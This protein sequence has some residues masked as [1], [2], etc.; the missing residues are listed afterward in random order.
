MMAEHTLMSCLKAT[1]SE[2]IATLE[3]FADMKGEMWW[4][5]K[6]QKDHGVTLV[7]HIDTV[8]DSS[9]KK[10]EF[11]QVTHTSREVTVN[12]IR[13]RIYFDKKEGVIW[14][15]DGLGAD[16]RAGVFALFYIWERLPEELRPNLLFTDLEEKGGQGA[17]AVCKENMNELQKATAFVQF[18]RKNHQDAVFYNDEPK[19]FREYVC[20]FGFKEANGSFSDV[21]VIGKETQTCAVNLSCGYYDQHTKGEHLYIS[22]LFGSLKNALVMIQ[23][24]QADDRKWVNEAK[25]KDNWYRGPVHS[26]SCVCADC[27]RY[28]RLYDGL[29][30]NAECSPDWGH[31]SYDKSLSEEVSEA[32]R[33]LFQQQLGQK[34]VE[35]YN[36]IKREQGKK[37]KKGRG[38]AHHPQCRCVVCV[39]R[40]FRLL[41]GQKHHAWCGCEHCNPTHGD[42]ITRIVGPNGEL[43]VIT[44]TGHIR[45]YDLKGVP[46]TKEPEKTADPEKTAETAPAS[47]GN[48]EAV[49]QT[50]SSSVPA[51]AP[52]SREYSLWKDG[53][54]WKRH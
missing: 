10:W 45:T 53:K 46:S 13:R 38:S 24:M 3:D 50:A 54:W 41:E 8:W 49:A 51:P 47:P 27:T 44:L 5:K 39:Q 2:L 21:S 36:K 32:Q 14:S 26:V 25:K 43:I 12:E 11:D 20:S 16:D 30:E 33:S 23:K 6:S 35:I 28:D 29:G 15:P 22:D 37:G 7:A 17:R 31:S 52:P 4:Y 34:G 1:K 40:R 42:R 19:I 9:A 18:D 48:G